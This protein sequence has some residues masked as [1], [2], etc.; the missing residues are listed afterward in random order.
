M[1]ERIITIK[2]YKEFESKMSTP[3]FMVY[4]SPIGDATPLYSEDV[5]V[6]VKIVI[7][8]IPHNRLKEE[9]Y[10]LK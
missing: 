10:W 5:V 4:E 6:S 1:E 7:D 8:K 9:F 2:Q 3:E